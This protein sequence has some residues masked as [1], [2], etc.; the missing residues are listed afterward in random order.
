MQ[1]AAYVRVST[2]D[3]NEQHQMRAIREKYANPKQ[4][5]SNKTEWYCDLSESAASTSRREYQY[6]RKHVTE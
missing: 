5:N 3:Q 2:D 1:I 6:L 4:N